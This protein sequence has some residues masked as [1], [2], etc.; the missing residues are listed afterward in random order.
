MPIDHDP[1]TAIVLDIQRASLHDGPGLRTTVFLKGCP[2]RCQWCHNPE[3]ID[4]NP[5]TV[6]T[7]KGEPKTYGQ[8]ITVAD[9]MAIIIKDKA[10]YQN[11]GGGLTISGGEP[12][13]AFAFTHALATTARREGIHVALDTTGFGNANQWRQ[14]LDVVD[15]FLFD[16]KATGE[17]LH[18]ELTGF[19]AAPLLQSLR[20]LSD[21]GANIILRCP[22]IPGLNDTTE[23][24]AAIRQLRQTHAGIIDVNLMPYH[25]V[26]RYKYDELQQP[27]P[28]A[29]TSIPTPD[30]I[31]AW[32]HAI[33]PP[34]DPNA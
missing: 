24:F 16:Y 4:P 25:D 18:R 20:F 28:L 33:T 10:F 26:A 12:M 6:T 22:I 1:P 29:N 14:M 23:H 7:A 34:P 13:L 11:S 5:V 8:R 32:Q 19:P 31:Q 15:L 3:S 27:Y 9:V 30:Q 17:T 21:H 2:L